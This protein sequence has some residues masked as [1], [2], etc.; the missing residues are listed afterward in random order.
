MKNYSRKGLSILLSATIAMGTLYNGSSV[1]AAPSLVQPGTPYDS[2]G[3][4]DKSVPHVVINQVYGAGLKTDNA[5]G[6]SHG[7][8]ELY[9][10][11]DSDVSLDGW[12]IQYADRGD[13]S[14][15]GPTKAW[16]KLDIIGSQYVIRAHSSFLITAKETKANS[17]ALNMTS[18]DLTWDRWI[19]NKGMKVALMSNQNLLPTPIAD[20]PFLTKP[21]GFVDMLGTGSNDPGSTI[22]EFETDYPTG[23]T[24]GTSKKNAL[25][26]VNFKDSD[27]NK[28][29]FKQ[30]NYDNLIIK[31]TDT[32]E[33]I[34]AKLAGLA[35]IK[36]HSGIEGAWYAPLGIANT[37]LPGATIGTPYSHSISDAVYGGHS[38]YAINVTGLPVGLNYNDGKIEGTP[39]AGSAGI[40]TVGV[41]VTDSSSKVASQLFTLN[42]GQANDNLA[43]TTTTL[44]NATIGQIY[45]AS[46]LTTG[47]TAPLT[48]SATGLPSGLVMNESTGEISGTPSP[49]RAATI[50]VN[51]IVTDGS[52]FVRNVKL[53]LTIMPEDIHYTD[54]LNVTKIGSYSV[55][56]TNADGG[57]AE[58]V[59]YNKDNGK[60][61]LVNGSTNPPTL[62]IV[63]LT[64]SSTLTK[65]T[66]LNVKE[67]SERGGDFAYGDLTSV[68]INT[69]T[70][71]IA[72]S[73]QEADYSKAG[74]ILILDYEGNLLKT[75]PAGVQPDMIK[76]TPDGRYIL[77]ADE[78][79]P[80]M[81]SGPGLVDPEGSITIVDTTEG[82]I[83]HVKFD[84]PD[85]I[86][87]DV[88]VRGPAGLDGQI[89]T[90]GTKADAVRDF[91]PEYIALSADYKKAYVSLQENNAIA[92]IDIANKSVISVKSLGFK[93][94]NDARNV[95][96]LVKDG[97][98]KL[99]NVPFKGLYM[100]DGIATHSIGGKTYLF[101]ANEGDATEWPVTEPFTRVS[102]SKV[103]K[104]KGKLDPNSEAAL[105]LKDK[106]KMFDKVEVLSD[107]GTDSIYM[108]GGRSFSIWEADSLNQVYDSGSDFE[109]ITASRHAQYFN[110]G[111]NNL[112]LDS[113]SA[114]KGPEPEDIKTGKVGNKVFAFVGLERIGGIM[115][116]DVTDPANAT[117]ANYINTRVF[118]S[119]N[120]LGTD[121]GPEGIEF[122][123][124]ADSPTG[125]PLLLV[126]YEVGGTV[127]VLQ[128]NVTKVEI[129]KK[130]IS[131]KVGDTATKL[132][133]TVTPMGGSAATV[134]WSSSNSAVASVDAQGNVT[135]VSVGTATITALSADGYGE[136]QVTF[137]V[138]A[139][140]TNPGTSNPGTG[141]GTGT[142]TGSTSPETP[143]PPVNDGSKVTTEVKATTNN[144]GTAEAT[145]TAT[146]VAEALA[147]S[148]KA[149]VNGVAAALE[150]KAVVTGDARE[151]I[152]NIP[153]DS[154]TLIAGSSVSSI[155]INGSIG[156]VTFDKKALNAILAGAPSGEVS[157]TIKKTTGATGSNAIVSG[158]PVFEII[159]SA[160]SKT[161]M[162][163][164]GGAVGLSL[165]Y[166]PA[167]NEDS[168]AIVVY[169]LSDTGKLVLLPYSHY[170]PATGTVSFSGNGSSKYVIG[171][172]K[173]QFTDT[174]SSFAEDYITYLAARG[175]IGGIGN[176]KFAPANKIT[177]ADL[178]VI[179]ARL[180]NA[181]LSINSASSFTDVDSDRYY[182]KSIQWAVDNGIAGGT[183]Q[184]LFDPL[185]FVT[186]EQLVTLIARYVAFM[187][188]T[189]PR[190]VD[191]ITFV[192]QGKVPAYATNA[193]RVV[194]QAGMI[195]GKTSAGQT[196]FAPKDTAT[197]AETAKILAI[198][199]Q[200][201]TK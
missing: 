174:T 184:D 109:R 191:A 153:A 194:Q 125:L 11:T 193:L 62:D 80:R 22:D 179:L 161:V 145:F 5:V 149:A 45:S 91:E 86:A 75:Y 19:N 182:S 77:T 69:T 185:A 201:M 131:A 56:S 130:T 8:I 97:A 144:T 189:L 132:T 122:I 166:K 177:R 40:A 155:T 160:G 82:S 35:E 83:T 136:A 21:D 64:Q 42:V 192:D 30:T 96:D 137:T 121:T 7:F 33:V 17:P 16:E 13:N 32:P 143:K 87:D 31:I 156:A 100:P 28:A 120:V 73:V 36:P 65:D 134:T 49:G 38:P 10:P 115:T 72:V 79:E 81:G 18:P 92:T 104:L 48:Y 114:K 43:I 102:S 52:A 26:R 34:A 116:Y 113:R 15:T 146:Q 105:F 117:F 151:A 123:P 103:E 68:D 6:V 53:P 196:L 171:Y 59:K 148:N 60:F 70:K 85:V 46:I 93:D 50:Q 141:G 142:G 25:R 12:S 164:G 94:F 20:N 111:H 2:N 158:R 95:L 129:D 88:H 51:V 119:T 195:S 190:N 165:P 55:G 98:I 37:T 172:N 173:Q 29:D 162:S 157:I 41:Q 124:A 3:I 108:Y 66:S 127:A 186:R 99:E 133:P 47:G 199:M 61:Y 39:A 170:D 175:V 101:T 135:P 23:D 178:I 138:T 44:P 154:L 74:K 76:S 90:K 152:L 181:D 63:S 106:G 118:D 188:F 27:V 4:Y 110:A 67:L 54:I 107:M 198:L 58:I 150:F 159:V 183:G 84:Q 24:G 1:L 140:S 147:A 57:V 169:S 168:N 78:G 71:K 187:N 14:I 126:A 112:D 89:T 9:N 180:A 197:R 139:K 200:M 167:A 176:N 163:Y 128:L